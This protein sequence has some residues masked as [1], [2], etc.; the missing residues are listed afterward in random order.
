M[1]GGE[2]A[3][4]GATGGD[5]RRVGIAASKEVVEDAGEAPVI[6]GDEVFSRG[7][8]VTPAGEA[9][10]FIGAAL[11]TV[12]GEVDGDGEIAVSGESVPGLTVV[13]FTES[14]VDSARENE[15]GGSG[16]RGVFRAPETVLDPI[17]GFA[18]FDDSGRGTG[19]GG[20]NGRLC[21]SRRGGS[22]E[23]VQEEQDGYQD[24]H[25]AGSELLGASAMSRQD[26]AGICTGGAS[27]VR[28]EDQVLSSGYDQRSLRGEPPSTIGV[29]RFSELWT[30]IS[31]SIPKAW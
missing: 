31:G 13:G 23:E 6:R 5:S 1:E 14:D 17:R 29:G 28:S 11:R 10:G 19:R 4:R 18:V 21:G 7:S 3:A 16:A 20:G 12:A 24:P 26:A 15:E 2:P 9:F 8:T 22:D 27:D 25:G 30:R